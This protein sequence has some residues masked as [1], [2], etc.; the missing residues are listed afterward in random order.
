MLVWL[1][2]NQGLSTK[3]R[4]FEVYLNI[5][6]WGPLVYGANEA[7][8]FYFNKDAAKLNLAES[9]FLA[10]II[11]KPKWFK[12]SFN[13]TGHLRESQVAYFELL[14]EKMLNRG[15]ISQHDFDNL[16]PDVKLKGP[17]KLLLKRNDIIPADS[18]SDA[19]ER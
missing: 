15:L 16:I 12:Y 10:S 4:M 18:I 2:E 1:I 17:A 11:P 5:I 6:E 7:A 13:E 14:S 9:I 3:D 19:E 8:R